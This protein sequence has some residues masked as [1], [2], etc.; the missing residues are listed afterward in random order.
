MVEE[1]RTL[2]TTVINGDHDLLLDLQGLLH[3]KAPNMNWVDCSNLQVAYRSKLRE[4]RGACTGK[5][6]A[7]WMDS[8]MLKH[9][10]PCPATTEV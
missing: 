4:S 2:R 7:V 1:V 3:D 5:S 10:D 6:N 9:C 8:I